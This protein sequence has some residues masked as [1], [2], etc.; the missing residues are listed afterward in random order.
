MP[1]ELNQVTDDNIFDG[2]LDEI[3]DTPINE[4]SDDIAEEESSPVETAPAESAS[5]FLTV[6]YL[7]EEKNLTEDE[8]R[9][10]A[11][12]GMDYDRI[13]EKYDALSPYAADIK[14]LESL[15]AKNG[16][17]ISEYLSRLDDV[18]TEFEV[19]KELQTLK[20]SY[21]D[22]P[23]EVITELANK[24]VLEKQNIAIQNQTKLQSAEQEKA[25]KEIDLFLEE[26]P[27]FK[28]KGP[29]ALDPKVFEY[30][31]QGYSLLEAYYKWNTLNSKPVE[32]TR[33]EFDALNEMNRSTSIGN[34]ANAPSKGESDYDIYMEGF[35]KA[36][37]YF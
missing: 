4:E 27:E 6:K 36:N 1:E 8:A 24:R 34:T 7:Q 20:E 33:K 12:M 29:E 22:A 5:P 11:Q 19:S 18:Q 21:P 28:S 37:N 35:E 15:A 10:Y 32:E 3:D 25:Q 23:D 13:R 31:Q 16:T 2:M 14:R 30:V 17:S 26:F 9:K